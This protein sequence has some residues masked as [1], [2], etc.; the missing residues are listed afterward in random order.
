MTAV[1][2]ASAAPVQSVAG[3][4]GAV[5]LT[6]TDITDW[7]ATLAP[8]APLASPTFTGVPPAPTAAPGANT[9]QL[10]TTAI[11]SA[12]VTASVGGVSSFNGRSGAVTLTSADVTGALTF[13][14]Y[15]ATN[16][17]GYQTAAQVTAT[18]G[19]YALTANV[20]VASSTTPAMDGTA[21]VG[22]GTTW[23]RRRS[24]IHPTDTSRYAASNPSGFQTAAQVTAALPVA[25]S[26]TPLMDGIAAVGVGT[27]WARADHVHPTDTHAMG[28][29]RII[30]GDMR[31]DQR[32]NGASGTANGYTVDR[33]IV[34][35]LAGVGTWGR[36]LNAVTGPVGFPYYLGFQSSSAHV[37]AAT[38]SF[39]LYQA[40]EADFISDFAWGTA[41]A[42]PA[43]LSFWAYSSLT[44]TFSGS[45]KNYA[46]TRTYPFTFS[47]PTA[48]IWT[49]IVITVPGDTGGAWVM[50]GNGGAAYLMLDLGNGANYRGPANAWASAGYNAATG[51]VSVV[52]T[53]AATFYVT[54]V[55]LEIGSVATPY[56]RQ[57][58]AK[59]MADCQRYYCD[60][61]NGGSANI[62]YQIGVG[63]PAAVAYSTPVIYLPV[64]MRATPTTVSRNVSYGSASG[65]AL[66]PASPQTVQTVL[67]ATVA[68]GN[69]YAYFN[70]TASAEL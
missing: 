7:T 16:P 42:Q 8:Y 37:S 33:W 18:L 40:I 28:D 53:N 62:A 30:N 13:T 29:N 5:T 15:N 56:N 1:G 57:S 24:R 10:A 11:V 54:G 4:T 12:A 32:N 66:T 69:V 35:N 55:K 64:Y 68:G 38:D 43:T 48:N 21:A 45:I 67:T 6:H 59:S 34:A 9:T 22:V 31:V 26:T 51:S 46:Q 39:N 58:L 41:G 2:A 60:L 19:P 27:T 52:A 61:A 47:L 23:A 25:S 44:G 3:R 63:A 36:N 65:L 14:P 50:S 49:K 17:A 70:M 20:P